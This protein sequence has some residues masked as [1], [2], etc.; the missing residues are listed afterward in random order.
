MNIKKKYQEYIKLIN[1]L[2]I[3]IH[4]GH[5]YLTSKASEIDNDIIPLIIQYYQKEYYITFA[6]DKKM[7]G[8][9]ITKINNELIDSYIAKLN[10]SSYFDNNKLYLKQFIPKNEGTITLTIDNHENIEI[11]PVFKNVFFKTK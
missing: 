7:I 2:L 8:K 10:N 9:K 6:L 3:S 4:S 1:D 11:N 5:V